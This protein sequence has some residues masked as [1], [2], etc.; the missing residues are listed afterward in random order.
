MTPMKTI[1]LGDIHGNLPALEA[2]FERAEKLSYD[3]MVH[4]GDVVG[5]GPFPDECVAF[6]RQRNIPG[7]RGNF[8]ENVATDGDES[9]AG[10]AAVDERSIAEETFQ[11]TRRRIGL[12]SKRWLEDLPFELRRHDGGRS[13]AVYHAGPIDLRSG[14]TQETP[15]PRFL[16]FAEAAGAE[17]VVLGHVHRP[18]YRQV[19]RWHF[20]NAGSVG[21]PRDRNPHTGFAVI[22]ADGDVKVTFERFAYDVARTV[23]AIGERGLP[24][25]LA[26]R[27]QQGL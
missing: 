18:F 17:M 20:V 15:E 1:V 7:V 12:A 19:D 3:W 27:L 13:L 14:L 11:W 9:G 16:E 6:L 26:D 21:R 5:Y 8:D 2:C 25:L 24:P 10:D 4:T 22:E 23:R